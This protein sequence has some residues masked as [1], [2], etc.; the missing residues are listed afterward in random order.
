MPLLPNKGGIRRKKAA[1]SD[2]KNWLECARLLPAT[3]K[4]LPCFGGQ[5]VSPLNAYC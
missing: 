4:G 2:E 1:T 5:G 3:R